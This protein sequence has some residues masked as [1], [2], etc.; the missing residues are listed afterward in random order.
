MIDKK[1]RDTLKIISTATVVAAVPSL[2]N[3][4]SFASDVKPASTGLPNELANIDIKVRVSATSNDLELLVSNT[5]TEASNITR[6]TPSHLQTARGYFDMQ[7]L[8]ADGPLSLKPGEGVT[9]PLT[10]QA[11][12]HLSSVS[13]SLIEDLQERVSIITDNEAYAAV[14]V[15]RAPYF[16]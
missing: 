9:V 5:G 12:N 2:L 11:D 3:A 15:S 8:M 7:G 4:K 13:N 10:R 6:L 14:N 16:V 1:K